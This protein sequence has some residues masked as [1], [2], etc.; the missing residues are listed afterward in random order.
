MMEEVRT[1]IAD[2]VEINGSI[3]CSGGIKMA[4]KVNGDVTTTGDL[5][6]EKGAA[7]KGNVVAASVV[8]HGMIK[9]NVTAKER[10]ELKGSARVSGDIKARRL[11]VEEG[12]SLVGKSEITPSETASGEVSLDID[13]PVASTGDAGKGDEEVVKPSLS[14][15]PP[16]DP[17]A[18]PTSQIFA[19]K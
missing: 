13:V 12:V 6:V 1:I 9:G 4:G 5:A 18:R 10:I 3:K 2:D 16:M 14:A 7:I 15:R 8:V 11:V 17:R 19:R